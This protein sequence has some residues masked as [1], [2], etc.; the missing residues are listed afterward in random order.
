MTGVLP[1]GLE[2]STKVIG[3]VVHSIKEYVMVVQL[4]GDASEQDVRRVAGYFRGEIYQRP[5]VRS[6]V[7]RALRVRRIYEIEVLEVRERLLLLRVLSDPG[8]YMRKL[9]HDM[10]LMLGVGAHMRE[11]RRTR[12]GPFRE[13]ETLV[14]LQD[15]SEALALWRERGDE[16][17]LRRII[18]PVE[19]SIVHLPKIMILD[20]AVDA[21]AHGASLAAPGVARLTSNVARNKTVAILTLK[22]ELV[23][24]GQALRD[25]S[26]IARMSKGIVARTR[27]VLMPP[28][29]YPSTWKKGSQ[30]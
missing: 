27:R 23:A 15:V 17:Y 18:L 12:T 22:G 26:E 4:H 8:T 7:K 14:R 13:D 28:G 19:A 5:P 6:S 21:I 20:T 16:R 1:V 3:S 2:N 24:L 30:L 29:V 10:G 25:A 11:L 9:A